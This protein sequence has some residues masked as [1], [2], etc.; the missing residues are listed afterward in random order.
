MRMTFSRLLESISRRFHFEALAVIP[1]H[2]GRGWCCRLVR[3][4]SA[5]P[6]EIRPRP[7][8][9][10]AGRPGR[11][12]APADQDQIRSQAIYRLN[13]P[14][15]AQT[16]LSA[17][18]RTAMME[19]RWLKNIKTEHNPTGKYR[20]DEA[21]SDTSEGKTVKFYDTATNKLVDHQTV[22]KDSELIV[23]GKQLKPVSKQDFDISKN[24]VTVH[25]EFNSE[26]AD[27][28]AEFTRN[29]VNDI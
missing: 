28:F 13:L 24:E 23:S 25:F 18:Q 7:E 6:R 10:H 20:I 16:T 9:G 17:L 19:F 29:H 8:E 5:L 26:G 12:Q 27:R 4:Q 11:G 1:R 2:I 22:L 3:P 15:D 14:Q 21:R